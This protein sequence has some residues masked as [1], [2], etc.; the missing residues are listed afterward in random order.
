MDERVEA[1]GKRDRKNS[2]IASWRS[3]MTGTPTSLS[4]SAANDE[5]VRQ[6]V[7]LD[8]RRTGA[9]GGPGHEGQAGPDEEREVLAQVVAEARALVALDVEPADPD[10]VELAVRRGRR[11]AQARTRRPA[12]RRRRAPR[13]RGGRAGPRRSRSGRSSRPAGGAPRRPRRRAQPSLQPAPEPEHLARPHVAAAGSCS[14]VSTT[15][16]AA[17]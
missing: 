4:G 1:R 12:G 16:S 13:P 15:S 6:A 9:G 7:D 2:G 3:R 10:A 14:T 11:P 5:E 8:E 17:S